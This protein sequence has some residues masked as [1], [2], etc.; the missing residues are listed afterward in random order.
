MKRNIIIILI[1]I[2]ALGL[3]AQSKGLQ[4]LQSLAVPGLSQ[5]RNGKSYGY[6][7]MTSEVGIISTLIVLNQEQQLREQEYYEFAIRHAHIAPRDYE[8]QY[9]RDLSRYNSSGFEANGYNAMIRQRAINLYPNDPAG[10]QQYIDENI[11]PEDY[12]W[13]W[14]SSGHRGQYS[15][16]RIKTQDLRDYGKMAIGVLI[17]NHLISGFDVLRYHSEDRRAKVYFDILDSAPMVK[18]NYEW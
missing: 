17:L 16:I 4:F 10:Q 6:A 8:D 14:D 15:Q 7:M 11:Y 18:I 9:F 1:L 5:V 12:A 2:S 3:S 13:Y